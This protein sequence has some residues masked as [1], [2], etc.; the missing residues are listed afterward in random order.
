MK[1]LHATQFHMFGL[2]IRSTQ[3]HMFGLEIMSHCVALIYEIRSH[4]IFFNKSYD[5]YMHKLMYIWKR[6]NV[7]IYVLIFILKM[8]Q[9]SYARPGNCAALC[10]INNNKNNI[11]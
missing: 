6:I 3:F 7:Y 4:F 10:G 9:I 2:E 1:L 8:Q 5:L 11:K